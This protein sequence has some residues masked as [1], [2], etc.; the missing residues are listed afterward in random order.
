MSNLIKLEFMAFDISCKN[1]LSW[2]LDAEI[3][4][5]SMY[6]E[7]T[8]IKGNKESQYDCA[9]ALFFLRHH[10]HEDLKNEYLSIKHSFTLWNDLKDRF[11]HQKTVILPKARY[12]W[13]HLRLQNFKTVSEYNSALF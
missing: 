5:T 11:D 13:I 4:L 7:E 9:K 10:L 2:I 3:H 1:Y 8:I 6:L 12:D